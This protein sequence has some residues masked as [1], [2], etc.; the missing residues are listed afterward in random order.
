M[1]L[2]PPPDVLLVDPLD[3]LQSKPYKYPEIAIFL[4]CQPEKS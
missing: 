4:L 1:W 3:A 2:K